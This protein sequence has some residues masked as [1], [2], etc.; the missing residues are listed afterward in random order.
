ML[1]PLI[2]YGPFPFEGDSETNNRARFYESK[3]PFI[4]NLASAPRIVVRFNPEPH[5][6]MMLIT[7]ENEYFLSR[8]NTDMT[9]AW[10]RHE[11]FSVENSEVVY[12]MQIMPK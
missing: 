6:H 11:F 10:L 4:A 2:N 9:D 7:G 8:H 1:K 5:G 12:K 3:P